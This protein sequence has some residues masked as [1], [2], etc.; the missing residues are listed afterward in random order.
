MGLHPD[1]KK[2]LKS[3]FPN[4]VNSKVPTEK[5]EVQVVDCMWLLFKFHPEEESTGEDLVDF[6]WNP[7][8][9]FVEAE[10]LV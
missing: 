10:G 2:Y 7:I 9:R 3:R 5:C 1:V 8:R 6:F 4:A